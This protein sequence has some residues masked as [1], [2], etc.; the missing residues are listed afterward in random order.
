MSHCEGVPY[1]DLSFL[2]WFL[3]HDLQDQELAI[4]ANDNMQVISIILDIE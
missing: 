2:N 3:K 4:S 1:I